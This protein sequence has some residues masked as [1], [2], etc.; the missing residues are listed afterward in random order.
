[1]E[2]K[3]ETAECE[4]ISE[5]VAL[6]SRLSAEDQ[7]KILEEIYELIAKLEAANDSREPEKSE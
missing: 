1:M 5:A 3:N 7:K 6:F 4:R 2:E